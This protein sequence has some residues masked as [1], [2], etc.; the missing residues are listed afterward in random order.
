MSKNFFLI[1][2]LQ[3]ALDERG[4]TSLVR[5]QITLKLVN[6]KCY[7]CKKKLS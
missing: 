2:Q 4:L 5:K 3:I 1:L 6:A 7:I